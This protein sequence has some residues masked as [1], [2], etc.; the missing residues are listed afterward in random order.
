MLDHWRNPSHCW[1]CITV[2]DLCTACPD[3][4][5]VGGNERHIWIHKY[6]T[7]LGR[8]LHIEVQM[9]GGSAFA[10]VVVADFSQ[11][12]PLMHQ[13]AADNSIGIEL[14]SDSCAC[15]AHARECSPY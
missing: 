12:I 11:Q 14:I 7:D 10:I 13:F 9:I 5:L 4:P 8:D 6:P 3:E 2:L 1:Y 15:I